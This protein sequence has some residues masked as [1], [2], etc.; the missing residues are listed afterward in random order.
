MECK[1]LGIGDEAKILSLNET[2]RKDFIE[3]NAAKEFLANSNNYFFVAVDEEIVGFTYG[4]RLDRLDKSEKMLYIHEVGV[5]EE[6]WNRGIGTEMLNA[7]RKHCLDNDIRKVFLFADSDNRAAMRLYEK[8]NAEK[9]DA[10]SIF[11]INI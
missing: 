8:Q 1:R 4:Y 9:A 11:F 10:D 5:L 6:Y 2:L 3:E 7:L